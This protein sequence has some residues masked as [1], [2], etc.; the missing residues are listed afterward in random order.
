MSSFFEG[1]N[2]DKTVLYC[3]SW[4]DTLIF[5]IDDLIVSPQIGTRQPRLTGADASET[6]GDS[7]KTRQ[8][9]SRNPNVRLILTED[10]SNAIPVTWVTQTKKMQLHTITRCGVKR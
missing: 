3:S 1:S 5:W 9:S 6:L 4:C 7:P 10:A 8:Q 2:W